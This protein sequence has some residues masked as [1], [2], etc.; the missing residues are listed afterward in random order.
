MLD[1]RI[2]SATADKL[3]DV[4]QV[5]AQP[6]ALVVPHRV[7]FEGDEVERLRHGNPGGSEWQLALF[8]MGT[9][10]R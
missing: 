10:A 3:H 8:E 1:Q 6:A 2:D 4:R 7:E 9:R 5:F